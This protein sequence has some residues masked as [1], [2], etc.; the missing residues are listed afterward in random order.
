M[1][2]QLPAYLTNR[3]G[4]QLA[5]TLAPLL[6]T[7]QPAHISI[8]QN[9]FRLVD[10]AGNEKPI[11]ELHL[12]VVIV[13]TNKHMSKIYYGTG[14]DPEN[15]AP[16]DCWSDNGSA[17]SSRAA[18]PQAQT[19]A[20][21]PKNVWGSDVSKMTGKPTKAC[22][23]V[24]KLAVVVPSDDN[25]LVYLL[26]IPPATLKHLGKYVQTIAANMIGA[27]RADPS[28]VVTRL[29]FDAQTQGVLNFTPVSM[30]DEQTCVFVDGLDAEKQIVPV[31]GGNDVPIAAGRVQTQVPGLAA[32]VAPVTQ[33]PPPNPFPAPQEAAPA[34]RK[35]GPKPKN[36]QAQEPTPAPAAAPFMPSTPQGAAP[37][38]FT[39]EEPAIP[40]FLQRNPTPAPA[41][42]PQGFGLAQGSAPDA[43]LAA[44]LDA[45]F[46]L[47]TG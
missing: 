36:Q 20:I 32:P 10:G 30:I 15:S 39:P 26:R 37:H 6:V 5:D 35:R 34:P 47:P 28:D 41:P 7:G 46:K 13:G 45:A 19:C 23:D 25:D 24:M 27:R 40:S 42:Q 12:D 4:L 3:R 9:R 16:P 11:N 31:V 43:G 33:L 44:A 38:P 14:Y 2:T 21:C 22:N 1:N 18:N 29:T 8:R 17:P